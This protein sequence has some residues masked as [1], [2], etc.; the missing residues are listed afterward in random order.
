MTETFFKAKAYGF[1]AR[2]QTGYVP[3][4]EVLKHAKIGAGTGPD[5]EYRGIR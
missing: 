5:V 2:I 3:K 1:I 4:P